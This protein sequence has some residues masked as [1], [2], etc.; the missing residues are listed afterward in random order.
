MR[1]TDLSIL[2]MVEV[3]LVKPRSTSLMPLVFRS[4]ASA[5]FANPASRIGS[6]GVE[7]QCLVCL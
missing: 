5:T 7:Q 6:D 3:T 1:P 4:I 2:S